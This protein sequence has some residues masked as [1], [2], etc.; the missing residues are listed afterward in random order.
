MYGLQLFRRFFLGAALALSVTGMAV[1][2][3]G[4]QQPAGDTIVTPGQTSITTDKESYA[5]GEPITITYTLPGPGFYRITD[6]QADKVS[7][8][9]SGFTSQVNGRIQGTVSPPT[10]KECLHLE[11]RSNRNV[12]SSAET[13]FEVTDKAGPGQQMVAPGIYTLRNK[14]SGFMLDSNPE[15]Q[16]YPHAPNDGAFQKWVLETAPDGYFFLRD[17]ATS[18]YLDSNPM[19]HVYTLEKNFGQYQQ[20]KL[21]PAPEGHFILRNRATSLMLADSSE[22]IF[23]GDPL[24]GAKADAKFQ[25]KLTAVQ[26]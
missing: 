10:G 16:V 26:P 5:V 13:C 2:A 21:E 18:Y 19:G 22:S 17:L 6:H 8:L 1:G 12:R 7:T 11:Y 20:W 25:W 4:A 23:T 14:G 3:A 15:K 24:V 9:R